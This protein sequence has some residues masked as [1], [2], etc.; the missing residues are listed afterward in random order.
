MHGKLKS[1]PYPSED[2]AARSA[3]GG[4]FINGRS[5]GTASWMARP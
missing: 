1:L 3:T 5:Q 4:T 2:I